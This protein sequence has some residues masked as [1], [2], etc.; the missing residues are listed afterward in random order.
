ML[1]NYRAKTR[2]VDGVPLELW[3]CPAGRRLVS[4]QKNEL[5]VQNMV[6]VLEALQARRSI[7]GR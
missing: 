1:R 2:M 5:L 3:K 6:G 4:Y 7:A